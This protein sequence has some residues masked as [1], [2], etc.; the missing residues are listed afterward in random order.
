MINSNEKISQFKAD[1][2]VY[3]F[4]RNIL[5]VTVL[6]IGLVFVIVIRK[7]MEMKK[8]EPKSVNKD[9]EAITSNSGIDL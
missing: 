9:F 5:I 3:M 8:K 6:L 2:Q 7:I 1:A 4:E